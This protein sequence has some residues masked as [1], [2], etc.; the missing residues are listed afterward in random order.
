MRDLLEYLKTRRSVPS[1]QLGL[2]APTDEQI[3]EMLTIASRVPDHGKLSP[4]RFIL[5]KGDAGRRASNLLAEL[6]ARKNPDADEKRI[7]T[8]RTRLGNAPLMVAVVS[9]ARP[10]E[11]IPEFEQLLAAGNA[12][13]NLEHAAFALGFGAQWTTAWIAFD[14]DAGRLLGLREG[15]Q[16]VAL[17]HIGTPTMTPTDRSRPVVEDLVTEWHEPVA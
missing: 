11:K 15:E 4:W 10:H 3:M 12:A 8:E 5:F 9:T 14:A 2:P 6:Y 1:S 13:F 7:E 16:L 17:I